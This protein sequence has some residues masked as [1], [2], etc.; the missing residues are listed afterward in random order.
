MHNNPTKRRS[1]P[2]ITLLVLLSL[3][4]AACGDDSETT[5][6]DGAQKFRAGE[7]HIANALTAQW[8]GTEFLDATLDIFGPGEESGTFGEIVIE[9]VAKGK[10]GLDVD[11]RVFVD[12]IR[13]DY[14]ASSQT[15]IVFGDTLIAPLASTPLAS[16]SEPAIR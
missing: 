11:A 2:A 6:G 16:G 15:R 3:V 8:G 10:T 13:P 1:L 12:T 7:V 9:S 4:A 5:T 14:T